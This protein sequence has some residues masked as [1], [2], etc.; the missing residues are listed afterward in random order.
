M[1]RVAALQLCST[2]QVDENLQ[3]VA[4]LLQQVAAQQVEL[5][6]LPEMFSALGLNEQALRAAQQDVGVGKVHDFLAQQAAL[7]RLWIVAGTLPIR[8]GDGE[9]FSA[10][11]LVYDAA[12]QVVARY[13]KIH[14][15]DAV[16]SPSESYQE[17]ATTQA[18]DRI[19]VVDT[20]VGKV[21]LAVCYDIRF[22]QLFT[23]LFAQGAEILA[24]PAAFTVT[25]G[26]AHWQL[27]A[28]CRAVE[29]F[30][31]VIGACQGGTHAHGRQTYGHT[32]IVDPWG[33]VLDER[34]LLTP[35][36]VY[37]DIDLAQLHATRQAMGRVHTPIQ[38]FP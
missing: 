10:A 29:H 19:V 3:M 6:V 16:I 30:C 18:G 26:A 21:G 23:A 28:R 15:F 33:R 13:D 22:P 11:C 35:G 1:P 14:L 31:Y 8:S 17:S 12:G 37:A 25:T 2:L 36:I 9:K 24:I 4:T 34:T 27:L 32:L 38:H 7:H 20:P 5:V